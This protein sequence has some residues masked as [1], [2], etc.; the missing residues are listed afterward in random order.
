M[1][2]RH[3]M[4][5]SIRTRSYDVITRHFN[6][7]LD[8][9]RP[10]LR[11]GRREQL[12]FPVPTKLPARACA[13]RVGEPLPMKANFFAQLLISPRRVLV[14]V[15]VYGYIMFTIYLSFT[16]IHDDAEL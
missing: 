9:K 12:S 7:Q 15:C 5:A 6:G 1:G 2:T 10:P 13:R 16:D 11:R 4:P 3:A 14:L 8:D